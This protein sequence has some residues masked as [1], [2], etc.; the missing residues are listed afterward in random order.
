MEKAPVQTGT[1]KDFF[2]IYRLVVI[3]NALSSK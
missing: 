2:H 1:G 3:Q